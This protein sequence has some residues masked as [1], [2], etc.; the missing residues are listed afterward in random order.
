MRCYLRPWCVFS[1]PWPR[2][3]SIWV[4]TQKVTAREMWI[5][6]CH[7]H[8]SWPGKSPKKLVI[9]SHTLTSNA[10]TAL[11]S[12]SLLACCSVRSRSPSL[13]QWPRHSL[14]TSTSTFSPSETS[15]KGE[16]RS[17]ESVRM[18]SFRWLFS[19]PITGWASLASKCIYHCVNEI[20]KKCWA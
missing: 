18:G 15:A 7:G 4:T 10:F 5:P 12:H 9:H 14:T 13:W 8:R 6:H 1:T 3:A 17:A 19:W 2:T 11:H 16:S 20:K